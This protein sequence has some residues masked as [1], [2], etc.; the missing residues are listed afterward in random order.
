[1]TETLKKILQHPLTKAIFYAILT[2]LLAY[3][4]VKFPTNTPTA[5]TPDTPTPTAAIV[6]PPDVEFDTTHL[7]DL[8]LSGDLTVGD[9]AT[10]TD[11]LT[12]TDAL[13]I[14]DLTVGGG[15]GSTGCTISNAGALQCDGAATLGSTLSVADDITLAAG[16]DINPTTAT[17]SNVTFAAI[18][19]V[20]Y[21]D[22]TSKTMFVL[23]ANVDIIDT[24][25]LVT[26]AF[27]GSGTD[28]LDC[29]TSPQADPDDYVDGLDVSSAGINR[30]GDA[31]D[32]PAAAAGDIGSSAVTVKCLY[33]D[34]NSD[35]SAGGAIVTIW[36][37]VR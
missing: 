4:G 22:V 27:N 31:A 3:L 24:Y 17:N 9:D 28:V 12:V 11:D 20:A 36:Y 14:D 5:N 35:A 19:T 23:P 15:Y 7:T 10:I 2:A 26:T 32:M 6:R 16:K 34:Q 25:A 13:T 30:L 33:T 18:N 8:S 29:G 21:T 37:A 1:M